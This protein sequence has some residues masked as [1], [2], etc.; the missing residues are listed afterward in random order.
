MYLMPCQLLNL[1][2]ASGIILGAEIN[3][4]KSVSASV[5]GGTFFQGTG[6]TAKVNLKYYLP[7]NEIDGRY[8]IR[9]Y[10]AL[11]YA[12]KN[13]QYGVSDKIEGPPKQDVNYTE[14]KFISTGN[15]KVGSS[16]SRKKSWFMDFYVGAGVRYRVVRNTLTPYELDHIYHWHEGF[17]DRFTNSSCNG[18]CPS[19]TIGWKVGYR[20]S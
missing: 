15:L 19:I 4:Y 11:E 16:W 12:Y 14:D 3:I 18:F 9:H 6:N 8:E 7:L 13:Q 10:V 1:S 20:F 17:I 5:E 2:Y